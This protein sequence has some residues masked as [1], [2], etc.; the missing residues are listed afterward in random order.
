M[1]KPASDWE[2]QNSRNT[3]HLAYW[4]AAWLLSTALAAFGPKSIWEFNTWLTIFAIAINIALG[5][6]MILANKRLLEGLDELQQK[7][8][9]GAMGLSLGVGVV[10]GIGFEQLEDA[11]LISFEAEISHLIIIMALTYLVGIFIGQRRYQ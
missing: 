2:L 10:V 6:A 4:T 11:M 1:N 9:L 7:I 8:Q 3:R 5:F